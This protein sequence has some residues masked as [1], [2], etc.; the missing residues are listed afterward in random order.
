[1]E[2]LLPSQITLLPSIIISFLFIYYLLRK[3]K[4]TSNRRAPPEAGGGWPIIGHLPLFAGR[5][6]VH[7]VL[8][9]LADKHGP[10]FT[11]RLGAQRAIVVSNSEIARECFTGS[12]DKV[13]LNRPKSIAAVHLSHNYA[14]FGSSPYGP[15]WRE[16]RKIAMLELLSNHRLTML[17]HVWES[18]VKNSVK[19]LYEKWVKEGSSSVEMNRWFEDMI[20]KFAVRLIAG[21]QLIIA[22][23]GQPEVDE[24]IRKAFRAFFELMGVFTVGDAIPFLR[25][26]D[27]GGY[28]KE[29]K[30]TGKKMDDLLQEWLDEHKRRKISGEAAEVDKG[31]MGVMLEIL[32]GGTNNALKFDADT[33]NKATCMALAL[34]A[35]DT[36][37][38]TLTWAVALLLNN[39]HALKKAQEELDSQ[40]GGQ[41][42]VEESDIKNLVYIQAI[43]KETLRLYPPAQLIPP[44][45]TI[46][47]CT[48]GGYHVPMGTTL[49]VNLWKI[50]HNPQVWPNP[51]V[52]RPE[53]FLTTHKDVDLRGKHFDLLP[54][55]SG[56]RG[57]PGISLGLQIVQ[58]AL[59]S[60]VHAFEIATLDNE[61]VDMTESFGLTNV[62]AMPL[63]VVL[64][65]RLPS[66]VY[67]GW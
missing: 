27:L 34:G 6:L 19:E 18:E 61:P 46:E 60:L 57:C 3:K 2:F 36:T 32:D 9:A 24:G 35:T 58:F 55:G 40:I 45:E 26:L 14:N 63:E 16:V 21:K 30:R 31:F 66:R 42:Q 7:K 8:G 41:R 53:R 52:F 50:H 49:F 51:W 64:T 29:M 39:P 67:A 44:R 17:S 54:F 43:V 28:E 4:T 62:K 33:V 1:M 48:V 38:A 13:L 23:N 12:N 65:P 37:T 15:Y 56:R 11:I 22:G 47:D 10:I 20:F 25:W 5:K 59:A